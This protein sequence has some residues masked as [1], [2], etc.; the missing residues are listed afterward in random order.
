M[1]L[2]RKECID[3]L[4]W[5]HRSNKE[6][7]F[8]RIISTCS[9][10]SK[11]YIDRSTIMTD[12]GKQLEIHCTKGHQ[13]IVQ[14]EKNFKLLCTYGAMSYI[15]A[16]S[17]GTTADGTEYVCSVSWESALRFLRISLN[18]DGRWRQNNDSNN[19]NNNNDESLRFS[20]H[21]IIH[22]PYTFRLKH[23]MLD[24]AHSFHP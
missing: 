14:H 17:L 5:R 15:L 1:K 4:W 6:W 20:K 19:I 8:L 21:R 12:N 7:H 22:H 24:A 18:K 3:Q 10:V 9:N 16:F 2:K 11:M 13:V 23:K